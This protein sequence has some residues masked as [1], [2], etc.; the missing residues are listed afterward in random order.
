MK[1]AA[2]IDYGELL[3]AS[4]TDVLAT[5]FFAETV[6]QDESS[7]FHDLDSVSAFVEF[8]GDRKG[9]IWLSLSHG[10]LRRLAS[11]FLGTDTED[12]VSEEELKQVLGELANMICGSFLSRTDRHGNFIIHAPRCAAQIESLPEPQVSRHYNVE[13]GSM[14]VHFAA[15]EAV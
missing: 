12:D 3:S 5:M 9:C 13:G 14:Q 8:Q 1:A 7:P 11:S 10:C 15:A 2:T 6:P 4:I